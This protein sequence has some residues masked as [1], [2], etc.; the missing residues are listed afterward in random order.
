MTLALFLTE[1]RLI[2]ND[3]AM[4]WKCL[5]RKTP[6]AVNGFMVCSDMSPRF[7][8]SWLSEFRF[9]AWLESTL[10]MYDNRFNDLSK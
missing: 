9:Y 10:N 4:D 8:I 6:L 2:L 7:C 1:G 5:F 3:A